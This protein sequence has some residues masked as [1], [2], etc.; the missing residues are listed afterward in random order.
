M[1]KNGDIES[2]DQEPIRIGA[3]LV[4]ELLRVDL[5]EPLTDKIRLAPQRNRHALALLKDKLFQI[6]KNYSLTEM[7]CTVTS[8]LVERCSEYEIA[9]PIAEPDWGALILIDRLF[10]TVLEEQGLDADAQQWF[11]CLRIPVAR[12]ALQD[13][14]FF[15]AQQNLLRRFLDQAYLAL[16]SSTE[17]SRKVNREQLKLYATRLVDNLDLDV[18][19]VNSLC[20]EAQA[21]FA[22]QKEKVSKI[23]NQI[24]EL[25]TS[26]RKERVAEPR[27]VEHL[28]RVAAGKDLPILIIEFLH[29]EWRKSLLLTSMREGDTGSTWKRQLRITE[30]IVEFVS[31]CADLALREKYRGFFP[32]LIKNIRSLLVSVDAEQQLQDVLEP[33]E[34]VFSALLS[35]AVAE[36]DTVPTLKQVDQFVTPVEI[37][38][39]SQDSIEKIDALKEGDW[40]R[41]RTGD[42]SHEL[43]SVTLKGNSNESWILVSQSGKTV[44][45]KN[46]LQLAR[47]LDGAVIQILTQSQFW[48]HSIQQHFKI[49][50]Q[51]WLAHKKQMEALQKQLD[52]Q[53]EQEERD[54]AQ[55]EL[56]RQ[57]QEEQRRK[58]L[59]ALEN[60]HLNGPDVGVHDLSPSEACDDVDEYLG[61]RTISDD[62]MA[63]ALQAVEKIQVGG[64]ITQETS[65][66]A[67]RCKLAVKIRGIDKMVFVDRLGIKAL[68]TDKLELAKL[69]AYG[70]VTI[71]DAGTKFDNTLEQVVR[72]IQQE[73]K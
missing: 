72:S 67:Q 66:G 27:V 4:V 51:N 73:R 60:T 56:E 55:Q 37:S 42:G 9:L 33:V 1:S 12:Y 46:S 38:E 52:A 57:A 50:H 26:R 30:S 20:I 63:S 62:E 31:G 49:A 18:S 39:T 35:G 5:D 43:C 41:M 40:L 58:E 14:S 64:W 11:S 53:R 54:R 10:D 3:R 45:K 2:M 48:D 7:D 17:K 34:L 24:K 21:W 28:N 61:S 8:A 16:L 68:E 22:G 29:G 47:A 65:D 25:E 23:E 69:I 59:E 71:T 19:S 36:T 32:V 6:Q 15:F 70:A 44:A 13:Y